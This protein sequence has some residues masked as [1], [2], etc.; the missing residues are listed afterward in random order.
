MLS[1]REARAHSNRRGFTVSTVGDNFWMIQLTRK[2]HWFTDD[3]GVILGEYEVTKDDDPSWFATL[4]VEMGDN[5]QLKLVGITLSGGNLW[6]TAL[7]VKTLLNACMRVGMVT[8]WREN[9]DAV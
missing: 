6:S 4:Q 9:T 3:F 1:T 2:I 8:K 5:N 7:P